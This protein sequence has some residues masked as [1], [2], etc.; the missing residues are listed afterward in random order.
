LLL[1]ELKRYLLHQLK[2]QFPEA[3]VSTNCF[4]LSYVDSDQDVITITSQADLE[5]AFV[6]AK[7]EKVSNLPIQVQVDK[8]RFS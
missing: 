2:V 1:E 7:E 3:Q 5:A 6:Y 8:N 4:D